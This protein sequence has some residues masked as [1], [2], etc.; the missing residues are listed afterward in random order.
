MSFEVAAFWRQELQLND[1]RLAWLEEHPT[2]GQSIDL[3]RLLLA[4]SQRLPLDLILPWNSNQQTEWEPGSSTRE[5]RVLELLSAES[6]RWRSISLGVP[7]GA[8]TEASMSFLRCTT[9]LL[10]R[11]NIW[12]PYRESEMLAWDPDFPNFL[13]VCPRLRYFRSRRT[14]IVPMPR[15]GDG[16]YASLAVLLLHVS[17]SC[18]DTW[19]IL[20]RAALRLEEL[21]IELLR[22]PTDVNYTIPSP[23]TFT[24]LVD[25]RPGPRASKMFIANS[26]RISFPVLRTLE[27]QSLPLGDLRPLWERSPLPIEELVLNDV[28]LD[29][30]AA[31]ALPSF[32]RVCRLVLSDCTFMQPFFAAL[33]KPRSDG[34]GNLPALEVVVFINGTLVESREGE[35]LVRLVHAR[36]DAHLA[37]GPHAPRALREVVDEDDDVPTWAMDQIRHI[38]E[39]NPV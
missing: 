24:R 36:R 39:G 38:L 7:S 14:N 11:C 13:P 3:V 5:E 15:T 21:N 30:S 23:I 12:G 25:F 20:R 32:P 27:A 1:A 9:P 22:D 34:L 17:I 28:G 26:A 10:E 35:N 6:R 4:R 18:A 16:S 37:G 33:T 19:N 2:C 31:A 29:E 8:L